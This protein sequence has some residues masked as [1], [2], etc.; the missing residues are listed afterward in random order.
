MKV[1]SVNEYYNNVFL[2]DIEEFN[3]NGKKNAKLE[4]PLVSFINRNFPE[5]F[6][7]K[8]TLKFNNFTNSVVP[9]VAFNRGDQ[10]KE[11]SSIDLI[12]TLYS[13]TEP[14]K[15]ITSKQ[16]EQ[17]F[18]EVKIFIENIYN[19]KFVKILKEHQHNN[20]LGFCYEINEYDPK[21]INVILVTDKLMEKD[22]KTRVHEYFKPEKKDKVE[23]SY[24]TVD[25]SKL[26]EQYLS[27]IGN[28]DAKTVV[29]NANGIRIV[30]NNDL[31]GL[32]VFVKGSFIAN[33]YSQHGQKILQSNIRFFKKSSK[34]I[35]MKD[36]AI[37]EPSNFFAYNNGL[38]I[39]V[40]SAEIEDIDTSKGFCTIK[41]VTG[42]QIVN[43]GQTTATLSE[44]INSDDSSV[45]D[46]LLLPAKITIIKN[47]KN[48]DQIESR[49]AEYSNTQ[50]SVRISDLHSN[51]KFFIQLQEISRSIPTDNGSYWF[52]ERKDGEYRILSNDEN[53]FSENNPKEQKILKVDAAKALM[54]WGVLNSEGELEQKPWYAS[55]GNEKNMERFVD[56]ALK[57]LVADEM[58]F[59]KV[60][61]L[62]IIRRSMKDFFLG[63][64]KDMVF[65]YVISYIS[66]LSKGQMNFELIWKNQAVS[67]E[68]RKALKVLTKFIVKNGLESIE[69]RKFRT[70]KQSLRESAKR[71][72]SW[73]FL[74]EAKPKFSLTGIP[75]MKL[76]RKENNIK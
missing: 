48:R 6:T 27:S 51:N 46:D 61:C 44:I 54:C 67:I 3:K 7:N 65:N 21:D 76:S 49:I 10:K 15:I 28:L 14:L 9:V 63:D 40:S 19:G 45:L 29:M 73:I 47:Q 36:T 11:L 50:N 55:H 8:R 53:N 31:E 52:F 16:I 13:L 66:F 32:L 30:H 23:I 59:K 22:V 57:N 43:G 74:K 70:N 18:D 62:V 35:K 39:T 20:L 41:S 37:K 24:Y 69:W 2:N 33:L 17:K 4:D 26:Y 68:F 1:N 72:N 64:Y 12:I 75:E 34:N 56:E 25:M 60:V 58:L 5:V 38:S 42:F 71:Q